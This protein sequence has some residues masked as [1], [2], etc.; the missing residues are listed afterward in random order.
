MYVYFS[1]GITLFRW[2]KIP[3]LLWCTLARDAG[4]TKNVIL[5][6]Q[7]HT[8]AREIGNDV[9]KFIINNIL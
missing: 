7:N 3:H 6:L 4:T 1:P 8:T 5:T 2:N 9:A